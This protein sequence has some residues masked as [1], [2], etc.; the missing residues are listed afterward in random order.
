M[1][2]EESAALFDLEEA[3]FSA[4][5]LDKPA[6]W[7]G[8]TADQQKALRAVLD[9]IGEQQIISLDGHAGT[10]KTTAMKA[11][12]DLIQEEYDIWPVV[13]TPTNKAA[14]VLQSK[15]VSAAT[16]FARFFTLEEISKR[17]K[18]M[19]FLPNDCVTGKL[20]EGKI[21]RAAGVI[22]DEASMLTSWVLGHLRRMCETV[23]LVG[24]GNQLPPVGD[25]E[26]PHGY[27]CTRTHDATLTRVLRN[28]GAV[29]KLANAVRMSPDGRR[30]SGV[31]LD[32]YYPDERFETLF[33]VDR[34][35]LICW[36]NVIRRSLNARA[37]SVLGRQGV[38][39]TPGD[40]MICRDNY[41]DL[42][43]NG[44]QV[45]V[46]TFAWNIGERLAKVKLVLPSGE[47]PVVVVVDERAGIHGM[48]VKQ[49]AQDPVRNVPANDACRRW[50]YT[51]VTRAKE[52]VYVVDERWTRY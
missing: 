12:V 51:A 17:P 37:R 48:A 20:G 6:S 42:L 23:I 39:P 2:A 3:E 40:L 31:K 16:V 28:D 50:F 52:G 21:S 14:T 27:F 43:L 19:V 26:T 44:T 41:S 1:N 15:G 33:I 4:G 38:L 45:T 24:D 5:K 11:L 9:L 47:W 36:R 13:V 49:F 35:Q 30:L 10:G 8:L 22:V 46:E 25:R 7:Y 34:P 29:L 32:D 18:K